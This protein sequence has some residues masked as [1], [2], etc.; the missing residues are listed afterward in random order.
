M[1]SHKGQYHYRS[2]S[3]KQELRGAALDRFLLHMQ[4]KCWD[5][6]LV[7]HVSVNDLITD[8]FEAFRR[9][10]FRNQRVDKEVLRDSNA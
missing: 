9:R 6:V 4:G 10:A 2:S 1:V 7:P 3:T 5:G 8:T